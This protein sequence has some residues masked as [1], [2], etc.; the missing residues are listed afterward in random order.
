MSFVSGPDSVSM[1]RA[2]RMRLR[3]AR[4]NSAKRSESSFEVVMTS[5]WRSLKAARQRSRQASSSP[6]SSGPGKMVGEF[7]SDGVEV[8]RR[9]EVIPSEHLEGRQVVV[10]PRL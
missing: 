8:K 4:A 10:V 6:S 5:R 1:A 9:I 2:V 7:A 3:I